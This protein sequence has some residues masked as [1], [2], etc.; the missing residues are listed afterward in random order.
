MLSSAHI[1]EDRGWEHLIPEQAL[2]QAG[3]KAGQVAHHDRED[4]ADATEQET[5]ALDAET[6]DTVFLLCVQHRWEAH[7]LLLFHCL[8][9]TLIFCIHTQTINQNNPN[10]NNNYR[11]T[12][13]V[14]F[15]ANDY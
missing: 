3:E 9:Y 4:P 1:A 15:L 5:P 2:L 11:N 8:L 12:S 14:P 6:E 7:T 10:N 13:S